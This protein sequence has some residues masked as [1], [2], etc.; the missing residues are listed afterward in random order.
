MKTTTTTIIKGKVLGQNSISIKTRS[1]YDNY[2]NGLMA[3]IND[4]K[5]KIES[6]HEAFTTDSTEIDGERISS[7]SS[8]RFSFIIMSNC[9]AWEESGIITICSLERE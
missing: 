1:E 3:Y 2:T 8:D 4:K 9:I 5:R 6:N 7:F